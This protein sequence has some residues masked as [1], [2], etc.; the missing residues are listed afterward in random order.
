M[1]KR[2]VTTLIIGILALACAFGFTACNKESSPV[3]VT[4]ITLN[5]TELSLDFGGEEPLVATVQPEN[6]TDKTVIWTSSDE[7]VATVENG[8][9]SA[10]KVGTATITAKAGEFSATCGLTVN[11]RKLTES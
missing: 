2:F 4:G 1:R 10:L 11:S 9:V 5:K 6:A 8:K 7:S 3:S